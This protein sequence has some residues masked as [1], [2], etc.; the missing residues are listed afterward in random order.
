MRSC[1]SQCGCEAMDTR[2][3]A[4]VTNLVDTPSLAKCHNSDSGVNPTILT[5]A[6]ISLFENT[7]EVAILF[8]PAYADMACTVYREL[9]QRLAAELF[10]VASNEVLCAA[11]ADR[12]PAHVL[13][14]VECPLHPFSVAVR[15]QRPLPEAYAE[16]IAAHTGALYVDSTYAGAQQSA[17]DIGSLFRDCES[18][19]V[20]S[21]CPAICKYFTETY[22]NVTLACKTIA[23]ADRMAF[24]MRENTRATRLDTCQAFAV[25]Y[26]SPSFEHEATAL[27]AQ[28]GA[29]AR[30]YPV[31]LRDVSYERL[32]A[33]DTLDCIVLV[34]CPLFTPDIRLHIPLVSPHTVACW[35]A[36]VWADHAVP[37]NGAPTELVASGYVGEL[38][39]QRAYKGVPPRAMDSENMEIHEGRR[40]IAM[41][42]SDESPG[43]ATARPSENE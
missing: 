18:G 12:F 31:F 7:K 26:T 11:K 20:V 37:C 6:D 5:A 24:L 28:I 21:E 27:C 8:S 39:A 25:V 23:P 40:G 35:L 13:L 16:Q 36:G 4:N 41:G 14:G 10:L 30:A 17:S 29:R 22:E 43:A 15:L 33:I 3:K 1:T 32:I 42:Y 38:L 19:L 34:D 2:Q 9:E